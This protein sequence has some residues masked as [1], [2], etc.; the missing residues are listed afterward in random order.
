MVVLWSCRSDQITRRL[1]SWRA[2]WSRVRGGPRWSLRQLRR[3]AELQRVYL[4]A[5]LAAGLAGVVGFISWARRRARPGVTAA[6]TATLAAGH[7]GGV[8]LAGPYRV[9]PFTGWHLAQV[10]YVAIFA[11]LA[12]MQAGT[13]WRPA[14]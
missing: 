1:V 2:L 8:V 13:V 14:R 10:A 11:V 4:A 3:G 12:V 6:C 9:G 5:E 7:L